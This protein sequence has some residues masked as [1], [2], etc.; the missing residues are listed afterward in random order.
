MTFLVFPV[1]FSKGNGWNSVFHQ[2][3]DHQKS[4]NLVSGW[5][6]TA[7]RRSRR[8]HAAAKLAG[9]PQSRTVKP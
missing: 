6:G 2:P 8:V 9:C 5:L 7:M 1:L 4:P 3:L